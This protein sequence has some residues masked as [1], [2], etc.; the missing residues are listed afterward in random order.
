[1][2]SY[3]KPELYCETFELSQHIATCGIDVQSADTN[4]CH[5][6]TDPE[7]WY[8]EV[9]AIFDKSGGQGGCEAN[10]SDIEAYC[11]TVGSTEAGK[12]FAS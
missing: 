12:L 9:V 4:V 3:V 7:F 10:S 5:A 6:T 8:G 11:Y 2:R 1:M